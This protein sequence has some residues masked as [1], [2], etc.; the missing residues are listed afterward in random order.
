[1]LAPMLSHISAT[2]ARTLQGSPNTLFAFQLLSWLWLASVVAHMQTQWLPTLGVA[3][4]LLPSLGLLWKR[5]AFALGAGLGNTIMALQ[6]A[7]RCA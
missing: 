3:F 6:L 1:M 4:L 5:L 7:K 2:R